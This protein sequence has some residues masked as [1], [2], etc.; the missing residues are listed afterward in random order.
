M[1]KKKINSSALF[2]WPCTWLGFFRSRWASPP[3]HPW[4]RLEVDPFTILKALYPMGQ[5]ARSGEAGHTPQDKQLKTVKYLETVKHLETSTSRLSSTSKPSS[6]SRRAHRPSRSL[7]TSSRTWPSCAS[8]TPSAYVDTAESMQNEHR[9]LMPDNAH[10]RAMQILQLQ[11]LCSDLYF[12]G[13]RPDR[14]RS[15]K[16]GCLSSMRDVTPWAFPIHSSW[17]LILM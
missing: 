11:S 3:G 7:S 10:P 16:A 12:G 6:T 5:P 17:V 2:T 13:Q 15:S 14:Q 8:K 1:K 4:D 9:A